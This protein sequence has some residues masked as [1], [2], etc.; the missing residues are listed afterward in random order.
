M[1]IPIKPGLLIQ[2]QERCFQVFS[3]MKC[4]C[5]ER[6]SDRKVKVL[7]TDNGGEYVSTEFLE[8]E[9][10][11]HEHNIPKSP[12]QNGVAECMNR[13]LIVMTWS[14]YWDQI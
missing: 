7:C 8:G 2:A 10:I 13:T 4:T 14:I 3:E 6:I 1:I 11:C 5:V 12:Q 9:G